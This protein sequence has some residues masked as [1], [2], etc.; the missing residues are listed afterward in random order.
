MDCLPYAKSKFF[1]FFFFANYYFWRLR[2]LFHQT[3]YSYKF[4]MYPSSN[5]N[6]VWLTLPSKGLM[7]GQYVFRMAKSRSFY[8]FS[9]FN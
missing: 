8:G 4:E 6:G 9:I 3:I 2:T 7:R 1:F 5:K